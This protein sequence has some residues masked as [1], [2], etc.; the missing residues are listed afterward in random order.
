MICIKRSNDQTGCRGIFDGVINV[1]SSQDLRPARSNDSL[2]RKPP[3][4][5]PPPAASAFRR[6]PSP[7]NFCFLPSTHQLHTHH[8]N[9]RDRHRDG[10]LCLDLVARHTIPLEPPN[11]RSQGL[12]FGQ[13]SRSPSS[14]HPRTRDHPS[15]VHNGFTTDDMASTTSFVRLH[16]P[17]TVQSGLR[18]I[19]ALSDP[20]S[21]GSLPSSVSRF[22]AASFV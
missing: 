21:S 12:V 16:A 1:D 13:P 6:R 10:C 20:G 14:R 7:A 15:A 5:L 19:P 3:S 18:S 9:I 17:T 8:T 11:L 4:R 22:D 2:R